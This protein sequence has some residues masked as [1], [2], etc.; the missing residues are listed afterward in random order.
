ML[1]TIPIGLHA[2]KLM[3]LKI[4]TALIQQAIIF[5][6]NSQHLQA[7]DTTL[8]HRKCR[9]TVPV[10]LVLAK[11]SHDYSHEEYHL[12]YSSHRDSR[13]S[14]LSLGNGYSVAL[15]VLSKFQTKTVENWKSKLKIITQ[16]NSC[17]ITK[18]EKRP[19]NIQSHPTSCAGLVES[20]RHPPA[21]RAS[22]WS[23][24][25]TNRCRS[26]SASACNK[27]SGAG[28]EKS[29]FY[30]FFIVFIDFTVF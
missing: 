15:P 21:S 13:S 1:V 14:N 11:P 2:T 5:S 24:N 29:C 28:I 6:S 23:G 9:F 30:S 16:E 19:C 7:S 4:G 10:I 27:S 12:H 3:I 22:A 26:H 17:L 8:N 25:G 18:T 20:N